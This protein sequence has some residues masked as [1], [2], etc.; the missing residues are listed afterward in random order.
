LRKYRRLKEVSG[1]DMFDLQVRA[2]A[3]LHGQRVHLFPA[4][5]GAGPIYE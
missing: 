1:L 5:F 4:R 2:T 3:S